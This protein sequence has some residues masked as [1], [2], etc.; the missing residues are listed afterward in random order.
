MLDRLGPTLI[1]H[2]YENRLLYR[3]DNLAF[4]R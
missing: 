2:D 1:F 4:E 3:I